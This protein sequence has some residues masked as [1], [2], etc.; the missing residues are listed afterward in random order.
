[1][2]CEVNHPKTAREPNDK[3]KPTRVSG[4]LA[5]ETEDAARVAARFKPTLLECGE[6]VARIS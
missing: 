3:R 4:R 6:A 5:R 2:D 1:M